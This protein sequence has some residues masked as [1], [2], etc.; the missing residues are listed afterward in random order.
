MR[1]Q[2]GGDGQTNASP[3][4][5][6]K[7]NKGPTVQ[8]AGRL[9]EKAILNTGVVSDLPQKFHSNIEHPAYFIIY[10]V[11]KCA[12]RSFLQW[13]IFVCIVCARPN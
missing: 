7:G 6:A 9:T 11:N 2:V 8:P 3:T 1:R 12:L 10:K 13:R 5:T 4:H